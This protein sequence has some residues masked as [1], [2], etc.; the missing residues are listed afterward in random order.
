MQISNS[1]AT[2]TVK[3]ETLCS[4]CEAE[5]DTTGYPLWCKACRA[6][7]KREYE[8]TKRQMT[9]S[10]GY[11][12]GFTAGSAEMQRRLAVRVASLGNGK[13]TCLQIATWIRK[14]RFAR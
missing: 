2:E 12:A 4:K 7:N 8:A 10:R 11:A 3:N 14:F 13:F 1:E 5:L 6:A 9:E